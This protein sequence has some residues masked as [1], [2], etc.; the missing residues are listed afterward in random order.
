MRTWHKTR[1]NEDN[2]K[3]SHINEDFSM[4]N[5]KTKKQKNKNNQNQFLGRA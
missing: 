4:Q 3:L 2:K 5:K 1:V